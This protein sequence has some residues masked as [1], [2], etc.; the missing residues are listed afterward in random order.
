MTTEQMTRDEF[1]SR[2]KWDVDF[3]DTHEDF[4]HYQRVLVVL[5]R[6]PQ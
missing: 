4:A 6:E 3:A 1:E 5:Q 2:R